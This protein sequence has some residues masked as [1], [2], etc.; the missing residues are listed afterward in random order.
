[1]NEAVQKQWKEVITP[2]NNIFSVN[3]K[4]IWEYRDLLLILMRRDVLSIYKQTIL[5]PLWFFIQPILTT[6]TFVIIFSRVAKLSTAG[7]PPVLFYISGIVMWGYF[8]EC[9]LRTS[10]FLK[11]N[12]SILSKV[13]FPRLIVPL[14]LVL[15]NLVKFS[16]QILLFF[17]IYT[18]FVVTGNGSIHANWYA[19]LFPV[20][21]LLIAGLGLGFGMIISSLTTK[22]KDLVHLTTFGV[23]LMM[24]TST[25]IFPLAGYQD[26][27]YKLLIMANPMTGI[28]ETFRYGFLGIG[29]F[30]W[31]LLTYDAAFIA[32]FLVIGIVT[33][34]SIERNFVD[35]I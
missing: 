18:Y 15:T 16:I 26:S 13:Y 32:T 8:S 10:S 23:Q 4:E 17:I 28:I 21:I 6:A 3:L 22:Y 5:G 9:I 20:L 24:Y 31:G 2:D 33:F 25:V 29:E 1:M 35:T 27:K 12:T 7:L 11:D 34:N 30:S 14:S 19:L